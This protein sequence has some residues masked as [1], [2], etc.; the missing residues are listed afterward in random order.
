LRVGRRSL[1]EQPT[2]E[3]LSA[4]RQSISTPAVEKVAKET[5][6]G[7]SFG[8]QLRAGM[9]AQEKDKLDEHWKK[10]MTWLISLE[11]FG[12]EEFRQNLQES[13]EEQ[14]NMNMAQRAYMWGNHQIGGNLKTDFDKQRTELQELIKIVDE[15]TPS[16]KRV[17]RLL[18]YEARVALANEVGTTKAA[19]DKAMDQFENLHAMHSWLRRESSM[20]RLLPDNSADLAW[21][22]QVRPTREVSR[23]NRVMALKMMS[24]KDKKRRWYQKRKKIPPLWVRVQDDRR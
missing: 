8:E 16:E 11:E 18:T 7:R 22:M 23:L 2:K 19:V 1:S 21:M 3:G 9:T 20:G 17:P 12:F 13:L 6:S 5:A 24:H 10:H 14:D 4:L 15:M